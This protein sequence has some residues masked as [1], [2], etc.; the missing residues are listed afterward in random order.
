MAKGSELDTFSVNAL[1]FNAEKAKLKFNII[2]EEP[3]QE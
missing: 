3:I 1:G 2:P